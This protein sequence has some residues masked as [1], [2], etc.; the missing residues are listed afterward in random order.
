V[1]FSNPVVDPVTG[2]L[3]VPFLNFSNVDADLIRVL[4][5]DDAGQTFS[6]LQFNV[7]G[8]ADTYAFPSVQPGDL[9]DCG[10]SGGFRLTLHEGVNVGGRFGLPRYVN[11]TRLVLQPAAWAYDGQF[12]MLLGRSTSTIFGDPAG[13]S[14]VVAVFSPNGGKTWSTTVVAPSTKSDPQ[15]VHPAVTRDSDGVIYA[16]YYVQRTDGK[17]RTDVTTLRVKGGKLAVAGSQ[18]LSDASFDLPPTNIPLSASATT[19]F[20]RTIRACYGLGEYHG[21]TSGGEGFVAAWGD[22]RRQW[23]GPS[24]AGVTFPSAAPY[25]HPQAD[26]FVGKSDD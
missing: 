23:T 8:A 3:Y 10:S 13:G 12:G 18:P 5:S 20:D 15:H 17:L 24:G 6:M 4:V 9:I 19:N 1:Q 16:S 7:A 22:S 26:V 11:A 21:I 14:E 25:A 2:R